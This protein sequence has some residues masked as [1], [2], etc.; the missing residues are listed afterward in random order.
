MEVNGQPHAWATLPRWKDP[1]VSIEEAGGWTPTSVCALWTT[2]TS[3][4][5]VSIRTPD[6][7][8]RSWALYP[9]SR[10]EISLARVSIRT[11]DSPV[12]S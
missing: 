9:V 12:R 6:R 3:L 8:V 7:P 4:A 2:E 10:T 1:Q 5:P 11:P